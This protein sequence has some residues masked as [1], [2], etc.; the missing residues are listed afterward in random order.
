[1]WSPVYAPLTKPLVV[2]VPPR[3]SLGQGFVLS[4]WPNHIL[5]CGWTTSP[6]ASGDRPSGR[7]QLCRGGYGCCEHPCTR[8][9]MDLC[10][11]FSWVR[12]SERRCW[13]Q[14]NSTLPGFPKVAAS[15][16]TPTSCVWGSTFHLLPS[17]YHPL[18]DSGHPKGCHV[19]SH[20]VFNN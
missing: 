9:W 18:F 16:S 12:T 19:A 1:M 3:G 13:S 15:F 17:T 2:K 14:G 11:R 4:L 20:C 8:V 5:P 7:L 6:P 10:F